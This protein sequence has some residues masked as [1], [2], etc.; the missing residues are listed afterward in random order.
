[1]KLLLLNV[2]RG[3]Y[4]VTADA[5]NRIIDPG[6]EPRAP[7]HPGGAGEGAEGYPVLDLHAAAG[8]APGGSRVYLILETEGRR[9]V[10]PVDSAEEIREVPGSSIAPLP[11]FIFASTPGLFR[12]LFPDSAGPRLLLDERALR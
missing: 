6:E 7:L 2:G 12:G 5:V 4:A 11:S 8:E 10:V 9:T 1:M 3:R